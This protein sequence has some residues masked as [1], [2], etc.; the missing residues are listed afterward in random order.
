[1]IIIQALLIAIA[2]AI[3]IGLAKRLSKMSF[4]VTMPCY[5]MLVC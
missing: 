1:M 4:I 5:L 2:L 3:S